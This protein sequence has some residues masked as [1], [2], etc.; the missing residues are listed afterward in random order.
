[1][2]RSAV[3]AGATGLVGGHVLDALLADDAYRDVRTLGR[4]ILD[5]THAKL[6]QHLVDFDQLDAHAD[7]LAV[8]DVFCCLGTTIKKAGSQE[9]F[10]KVDL[11]YPAELARIAAAQGVKQYL[12]VSAMGADPNASVFY[13]RVKG[14]AEQ[15]VQQPDFR[16]VYLLRPSLL[17]GDRNEV[18]LGEQIGEV[19]MQALRFVMIGPLRPYRAIEASDV[20]GAMLAFAKAQPSGVQVYPSDAIQQWADEAQN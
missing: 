9:A 11:H 13:N 10:R 20:A 3:L 2:S 19:V 18:R 7:L 1:M 8:D 16:G 4:R 6:T 17:L 12:M 15:A 14:E 5:R